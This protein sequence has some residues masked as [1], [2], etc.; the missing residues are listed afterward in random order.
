MRRQEIEI[1]GA[2]CAYWEYGE[3]G[4]PII[5]VHG[6]RGDHHGLELIAQRLQQLAADSGEPLRIIVPDLP[7]FGRSQPLPTTHDISAYGSWLQEFAAHF[8]ARFLVAHS[9]GTLVA[10]A[11]LEAGYR[12]EQ[13]SLINPISAPALEGPRGVLTK[14]AVGYYQLGKALPEKLANPLLS[15]R[16]IVRGMSVAMAKTGDRELRS[17]IH[18]QHDKYFS[19]YA[20]REML[21]QAFTASI[22]NTVTARA[23]YITMPTAVI[24][25]DKDDI[26][27]LVKQLEL[28]R[29]LPAAQLYPI[30]GVGHL[31]HY[32][33][34]HEAA[35]IIW[36]S[37]VA[38][39]RQK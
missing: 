15:H 6:F 1:A 18:N 5:L 23:Q 19:V 32:E 16:L 29:M 36:R 10:T 7:G 13:L 3:S 27:P 24:A 21:L 26:T 17:W 14:L 38:V 30:G 39:Q 2:S 12:P 4:E 37:I 28:V 9:F 25:G 22:T 8:G 11:A 31:V 34:P 35:E 20:N 33:A